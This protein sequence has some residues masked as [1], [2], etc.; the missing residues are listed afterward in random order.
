[1]FSTPGAADQGQKM[2]AAGSAGAAGSRGDHEQLT[3]LIEQLKTALAGAT[4][5]QES[6]LNEL[7]GLRGEVDAL[8]TSVRESQS[9]GGG[10]GAG[11]HGMAGW[12]ASPS[13]SFRP[14][15]KVHDDRTPQTPPSSERQMSPWG[16]GGR[17]SGNDDERRTAVANDSDLQKA[18]R[19]VTKHQANEIFGQRDGVTLASFD[20][21][22]MSHRH[23]VNQK[24]DPHPYMVRPTSIFR[25]TWDLVSMF[26]IVFIAF[27]L[28]FRI[29]FVSEWSLSWEVIDFL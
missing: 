20:Q 12:D 18:L 25:F 4:D 22:R 14:S 24:K 5:G 15:R 1:M 13:S 29:A 7:A 17:R 27:T 2:G 21:S 3:N 8:R 9:G 23:P 16:G 11:S 19:F 10:G 28:P 6:V 26:L